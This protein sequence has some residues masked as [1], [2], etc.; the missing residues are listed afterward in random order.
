MFY[1]HWLTSLQVI[2]K[3]THTH[4]PQANPA[5]WG[6]GWSVFFDT[7]MRLG[8]CLGV[9]FKPVCV[10]PSWPKGELYLCK[11]I[12]IIAPTP[13]AIHVFFT[14]TP[15]SPH[16]LPL[17]LWVPHSGVLHPASGPS[18]RAAECRGWWGIVRSDDS[19][20]RDSSRG[21]GAHRSSAE[22]DSR[23]WGR[24]RRPPGGVMG[25]WGRTHTNPLTWLA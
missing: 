19:R 10:H 2:L 20:Q 22:G 13:A 8:V 3:H 16:S 17:Q 7:K 12:T 5:T 14:P 11:C 24:R 4:T 6:S 18:R 15:H 25:R 21:S 23:R 9:Y 1:Q